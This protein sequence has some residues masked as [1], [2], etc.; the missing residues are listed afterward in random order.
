MSEHINAVITGTGS[1]IPEIKVSNFDFEKTL[2]TSDEWIVSRTGI[3][4]RH[5]A[6]KGETTADMAYQAA[7]RAIE[8]SGCDPAEIDMIVVGTI[9]PDYSLPSTATLIQARL[10]AVNSAAFD[11]AAAC[12]GFIHA[13]NIGR[14]M[15][16]AD[17]YERILVVGAEK[18]THLLDFSDRSTCVLFGDGA[19]AAVIEKKY[20]ASHRGVLGSYLN[21]DGTKKELLWVPVGGVAEPFTSDN[22]DASGRYLHMQGNE[23]FKLAVRAMCDAA[24]VA[25]RKSNLTV[26]QI[27]WLIPHQA[28]IRIIDGVARRLKI[29]RDKVFFNIEKV[30]NTSAASVPL[31]LD[32]ARRKGL[33]KDGDVVL[34]VA[35]GGGLAWGAALIKW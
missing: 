20:E 12:A 31:A 23:I 25:L 26:N 11:I 30:G 27:D 32:E 13:L 8:D 34:M 9:T 28:N 21:S 35:F 14:A 1:Y 2:D 15:M 17:E 4:N 18:L 6:A 24:R 7:S 33:I 3:R 19:G 5:Y 29:E 22:V 10:G 16:I